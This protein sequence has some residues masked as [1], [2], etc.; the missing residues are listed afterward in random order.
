MRQHGSE[1]IGEIDNGA[2]LTI[3]GTVV[4]LDRLRSDVGRNRLSERDVFAGASRVRRVGANRR[5][6]H[7]PRAHEEAQAVD[8]VD[9]CLS[10]W[11]E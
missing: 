5:R 7:F 2:L 11:V 9:H 10:L 3:E 1:R 4:Q 6:V 8:Q